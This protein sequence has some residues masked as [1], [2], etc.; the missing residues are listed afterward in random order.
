MDAVWMVKPIAPIIT[1]DALTPFRYPLRRPAPAKDTARIERVEIMR[2]LGI[3]LTFI[4]SERKS[5]FMNEIAADRI[6][7]Q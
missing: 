5:E 4:A 3:K 6:G 7:R 1:P 2:K